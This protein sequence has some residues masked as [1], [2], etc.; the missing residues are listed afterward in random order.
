MR[1]VIS[2]NDTKTIFIV[3]PPYE[4]IHSV[5][6][7]KELFVKKLINEGYLVVAIACEYK[8]ISIVEEEALNYRLVRINSFGFTN[9][10]LFWV[11]YVLACKGISRLP[12]YMKLRWDKVFKNS[13]LKTKLLKSILFL[14]SLLFKEETLFYVYRKIASVLQI[15]K[16]YQ[17]HRPL[18]TIFP[19]YFS[20]LR[21]TEIIAIARNN[22][23]TTLAIPARISTCD[24]VFYYAKPDLLLVWNE[25]MKRQVKSWH[26]CNINSVVPI[27]ILKCDYYKSEDYI[28]Q[29]Q[30]EFIRNSGLLNDRKIISIICGNISCIRAYQIARTI[31]NSKQIKFKFQVVLR[32][33]PDKFEDQ[34]KSLKGKD[35]L[36]IF[37]LRGFSSDIKKYA[38]SNQIIS[39]ADFL[40]NSNVI[41]SVASTMCLESLYFNTPNIYLIYEEFKRYYKYDYMQPLLDEQGIK[42][43]RNDAELIDA[44]NGY[45]E[46]HLLGSMQR[47]E[48]FRRYCFSIDGNALDNCFNEI[49]KIK[50]GYRLT[51]DGKSN[52]Y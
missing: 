18:M 24:D 41:I 6:Y 40:K 25:L 36:P 19:F 50:T 13:R 28:A 43:V 11:R 46:N 2:T 17:V 23:S 22:N 21:E 30:E 32:A 38:I 9:S 52:L 45:L 49:A 4:E 37:L 20:S 5:L 1:D 29:T 7:A 44:V 39:T 27:G 51:K 33:N 31:L 14:I 12:F 16:L 47:E 15:T 48:L 34:L 3:L 8:D 35:G 26:G 42:F 10:L